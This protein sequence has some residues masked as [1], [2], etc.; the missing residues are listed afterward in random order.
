MW[1]TQNR[2]LTPG[3]ARTRTASINRGVFNQKQ[4]VYGFTSGVFTFRSRCLLL[5]LLLLLHSSI[6]D[7][8][9]FLKEKRFATVEEIQKKIQEAVDM[10]TKDECGKCPGMEETPGTKRI[11]SQGE[12]RLKEECSFIT[13][14][15]GFFGSPLVNLLILPC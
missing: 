4:C 13:L 2:I 15:L 5:L 12:C 7:S 11:A 10:M 1:H 3:S 9:L 8:F 14:A 6:K